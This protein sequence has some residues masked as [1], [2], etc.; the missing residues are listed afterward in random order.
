[1]RDPGVELVGRLSEDAIAALR[2]R[3]EQPAPV[4][5]QDPG[6]VN[7]AQPTGPRVVNGARSTATVKRRTA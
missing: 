6:P 1:M 3:L 4:P 5:A 7:V 2:V